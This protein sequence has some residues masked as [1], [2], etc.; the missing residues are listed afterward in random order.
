[1]STPEQRVAATCADIRD[2]CNA[3]LAQWPAP[4]PAPALPRMPADLLA[5]IA[6]LAGLATAYLGDDK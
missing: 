5:E 1:M 3:I 4:K 6:A 2:T